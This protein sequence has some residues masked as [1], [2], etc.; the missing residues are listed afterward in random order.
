MLAVAFASGTGTNF[1]EALVE[2]HHSKANYTIPLLITDKDKIGALDYAKQF[3]VDTITVNG[4]QHCGSW[5]ELKKTIPGR[6][7]YIKKTNTY[8]NLL[9]KRI[10]QYE[11]DH[12]LTFDI[13]I[14]AKY[15]RLFTS[16]LLRRFQGTA[17]N[18]HPAD[19]AAKKEGKRIYVGAN[20][21]YNALLAGE[22]KTRTS[23]I[24]INKELDGGP[25]LVSGPW[26]KFKGKEV[27]AETTAVHEELQEEQSDWPALRFALREISLGHFAIDKTRFHDDGNP[28]I[29]YKGKELPYEGF[30]LK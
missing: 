17:L 7:E 18:V 9:L 14:L 19:L 24:L 13:A 3:S 1:R 16:D 20:A 22:K 6:K 4:I 25:I 23:I 12:H 27:T 28:I 26:V 15:M 29:F 8:N 21:V 30:V 2:S 11:Q 10:Q 5:K